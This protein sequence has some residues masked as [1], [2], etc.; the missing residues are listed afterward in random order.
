MHIFKI[1]RQ[2]LSKLSITSI[3]CTKNQ[4]RGGRIV[5]KGGLGQFADLRGAWPERGGGVSDGTEVGVGWGRVD[6]PMHTK[7]SQ[8]IFTCSKSTRE[9]LEAD[10][11]V[12]SLL[13]TLKTIHTIF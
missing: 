10:V 5:Q 6:T 12:M 13:L 2:S 7:T 4:Y 8:Q 1:D 11:V 9:K 3:V